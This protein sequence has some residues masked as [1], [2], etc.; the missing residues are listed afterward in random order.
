MT[1][2]D[3]RQCRVMQGP[4]FIPLHARVRDKH[5]DPT[6]P[7][8]KPVTCENFTAT[9]HS[10]SLVNPAQPCTLPLTCENVDGNAAPGRYGR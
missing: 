8:I 6:R 1:V 7:Y 5:Y 2:I 3:G 10:L 9:L 4:K